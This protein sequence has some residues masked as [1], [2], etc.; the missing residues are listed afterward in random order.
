MCSL[1]IYN[2]RKLQIKN[3]VFSAEESGKLKTKRTSCGQIV[4]SKTILFGDRKFVLA[5]A[6]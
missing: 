5:F 4:G 6:A 3:K 2:S 1:L